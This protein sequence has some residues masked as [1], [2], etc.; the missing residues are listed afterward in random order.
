MLADVRRRDRVIASP[1]H[2]AQRAAPAVAAAA[3][4]IAF[5]Y[6]SLSA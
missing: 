6:L 1:R 3:E 4:A 2:G 5:I